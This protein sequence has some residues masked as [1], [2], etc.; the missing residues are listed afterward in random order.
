MNFTRP[1]CKN[2]GIS[3]P[4]YV[5]RTPEYQIWK[6][7]EGNKI[8][9][10]LV[11]LGPSRV[12]RIFGVNKTTFE[13]CARLFAIFMCRDVFPNCDR[14]ESVIKEQMICRESCLYVAHVCIK[15]YKKLLTYY[16][17]RF[18]KNKKKYEWKLQPYRNA[19]DSPECWY[20]NPLKN[21]TGKIL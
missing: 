4:N 9:D 5:Y 3:L 21:L 18:P 2:L 16:G 7:N 1:F 20:F 12:S 11:R 15:I 6:N 13:K 14:T 10:A 19:G 8:Y 17:I